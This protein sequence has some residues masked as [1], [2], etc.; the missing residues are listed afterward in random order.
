MTDETPMKTI[1]NCET[2]EVQ[3]LPLS[4][5]EINQ[6]LIDQAESEARFQARQE[7]IAAKAAAKASAEVKLAA[8]GLTPEEIAAL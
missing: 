8:L 6:R 1:I 2:G 3:V 7:A 5:E 4:Q